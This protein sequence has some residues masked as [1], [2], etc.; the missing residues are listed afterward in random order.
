MLFEIL[1]F[2]ILFEMYSIS[3]R[4][5]KMGVYVTISYIFNRYV[6]Y[7]ARLMPIP[8][9]VKQMGIKSHIRTY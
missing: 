2:E 5:V 9:P 6:Y 8:I 1:K 7:F 4:D 3:Y